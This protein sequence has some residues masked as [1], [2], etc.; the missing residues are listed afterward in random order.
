M[1]KPIFQIVLIS[2]LALV[3]VIPAGA[4]EGQSAEA[5]AK[6]VETIAASIKVGH[7]YLN[8]PV[9]LDAG[10]P[11]RWIRLV[12]ASTGELEYEFHARL[13]FEN[14]RG[15]VF[16]DL[17]R[18]M[19]RSLVLEVE[20]ISEQEL[21]QL[22]PVDEPADQEKIYREPLRPGFHFSC[23]RGMLSDANGLFHYRGKWFMFYQHFPFDSFTDWEEYCSVGWGLAVSDNLVDW[24]ERADVLLPDAM[25]PAF[26]GSAVVDTGNMSGLGRGEDPPILLFY[27]AAGGKGRRSM[28]KLHTVCLAVSTDGGKTF[29][30]HAGN[31]IVGNI[32]LGNRDPKVVFDEKVGLW[33]MLV[34]SDTE[35]FITLTSKDLLSWE[36]L[37]GR[38]HA[39]DREFP[40]LSRL[41]MNGNVDDQRWVFLGADGGYA[42]A[43]VK[44]EGVVLASEQRVLHAGG[45]YKAGQ[46]FHN[47]PDGRVILMARFNNWF[48]GELFFNSMTVPL[49]LNLITDAED[50]PQVVAWPVAEFDQL[51]L[52]KRSAADVSLRDGL[53]LEAP[54]LA[55][56]E[57]TTNGASDLTLTIHGKEL[58]WDVARGTIH[59]GGKE[60]TVPVATSPMKVRILVD[61]S[62]IEIFE[63]NS[64]LYL[65]LTAR[66]ATGAPR[67]IELRGD[68]S[69]T[70]ETFDVWRLREM[71]RT[72]SGPGVR[73][74]SAPFKSADVLHH[75]DTWA[76]YEGGRFSIYYLIDEFS[77]G[78]AIGMAKSDDGV[79]WQDL[80]KVI[81]ASDEMVKF[82]GSGSIVKAPDGTY[83]MNYSEHYLAA[84]DKVRNRMLFATS[85]DLV[86]WTKSPRSQAFLPDTAAGYDADGRWDCI[87]PWPDPS[88]RG[89]VG[90]WTALNSRDI[91]IG[92]GRSPDGKTWECMAPPK[93]SPFVW[94]A[95]ALY[96][97]EGRFYAV[98]GHEGRTYVHRADTFDGEYRRQ[99]KHPAVFE[100]HAAYFP[101]TFVGPDGQALVN[102]QVSS[103][104]GT[105]IA[106]LKTISNEGQ[107]IF[108]SFWRGNEA[109]KGRPLAADRSWNFSMDS[110][111]FVEGVV[112]V[113]S[114]ENLATVHLDMGPSR[115]R[116]VFGKWGVV[117]LQKAEFGDFVTKSVI[118]RQTGARGP[119][120]FKLI[121]KNSVI[122]VY[123][124]DRLI[125]CFPVTD[126]M[127]YAVHPAT[128]R[129]DD[130]PF[131]DVRAWMIRSSDDE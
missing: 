124:K 37:P 51:R 10:N 111:V 115:H 48:E 28:D 106:P 120:Q 57:F 1:K 102:H 114:E 14:P 116:L 104:N 15:F 122:E 64:G 110:G 42:L 89:Y 74:Q 16:V 34:Y 7:R 52:D 62:G 108:L 30:K 126:R 41:P 25:G 56:L 118:D 3:P 17:E 44:A 23:R 24:E 61:R 59:W 54:D 31:P 97:T 112:D 60:Y 22:Q 84:G 8:L 20:G 91:C 65:P 21:A 94:E 66:F 79:F 87:C 70:L 71:S 88:G 131:S 9:R 127:D 35:G 68:G 96:T 86:N 27:T 50:K 18:W 67:R 53:G 129:L 119:T 85:T 33:V 72:R 128:L 5:G 11:Q 40:D 29:A 45:E 101:R 100:A 125:D 92:R 47:T 117:A 83:V 73:K 95:A 19:G 82:L 13:D 36:P 81:S 107:E 103:G 130:G 98:V 49:E 4:A 2:A 63:K 12:D 113:G 77:Y 93:Y 6:P 76:Y 69:G 55:D 105:F 58:R 99:Q 123:L 80:G 39:K 90:I 26:S 46:T 109:L 78:E 121:V 38:F 75:K 32:A 43:E